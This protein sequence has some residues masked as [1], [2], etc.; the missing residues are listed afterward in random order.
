MSVLFLQQINIKLNQ[1]S[2]EPLYLLAGLISAPPKPL[3]QTSR[4]LPL[5]KEL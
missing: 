1:F 3:C 4:I 5:K 2:F